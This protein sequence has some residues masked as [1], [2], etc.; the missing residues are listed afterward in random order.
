[1][2]VLLQRAGDKLELVV[3]DDGQ[4]CHSAETLK[5]ASSEGGF[6]R[7]S[8]RERMADLGGALEIDSEPGEGF[9]ATLV[10]PSAFG[11]RPEEP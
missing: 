2:Q 1:M 6:G 8:T 10:I 11:E 7:F 5:K 9:T 3:R 4:V